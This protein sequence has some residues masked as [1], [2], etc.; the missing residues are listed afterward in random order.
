[1]RQS[2][3]TKFICTGEELGRGAYGIILKA[4]DEKGAEYAIKRCIKT[5]NG[6]LF[7]LEIA[8][9][10]SLIHPSINGAIHVLANSKKID[11]IQDRAISDLRDYTSL[12]KKGNIPSLEL[13]KKWCF[14]IAEAL[15]ILH[16]HRIIHADIKANNVL[17][18]PNGEVKLSDFSLAAKKLT[19]D[20]K[21][22]HQVCT[23]THRAPEVFLHRTW[24]ESMDIWSLGCTF[25][26]I[27]FGEELFRHEGRDGKNKK[28]RDAG[29]VNALLDWFLFTSEETDG[30]MRTDQ[31]YIPCRPTEQ[32]KTPD[33]YLFQNLILNMLRFVPEE[34]LTIKQVL[35]HPFFDGMSRTAG[36]HLVN[37]ERP[38]PDLFRREVQ[39]YITQ[40]CPEDLNLKELVYQIFSR[41]SIQLDYIETK[42][43]VATCALLAYKILQ[44]PLKELRETLEI[45]NIKYNVVIE[46]E[47]AVCQDLNYHFI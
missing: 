19:L 44:E 32:F 16:E 23:C 20:T 38:L 28:Y 40:I 46:L 10:T 1:M 12:R 17:I 35:A 36:Y 37:L 4:V 34:R 30:L 26:E 2:C 15:S 14:S 13:L 7:P 6:V 22:S 43:L 45:L 47:T 24:D 5:E 25:Y 18:Y 39:H 8:I 31:N 33:Y 3:P 29:L 27:A 11:M 42:Y 21:F 9:M 41:C